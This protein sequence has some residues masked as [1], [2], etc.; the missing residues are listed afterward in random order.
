MTPGSWGLAASVSSSQH[1]GMLSGVGARGPPSLEPGHCT[2]AL[3]WLSTIPLGSAPCK[4]HF[5]ETHPMDRGYTTHVHI[6]RTDVHNN[7]DRT[8]VHPPSGVR[9]RAP[10]AR[11]AP[12]VSLTD[13]KLLLIDKIKSI[14]HF[15]LI[16]PCFSHKISLHT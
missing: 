3:L 11:C 1:N 4:E 13:H 6:L 7:N 8:E 16:I 9:T 15:T 10:P 12:V 5:S 2:H 14:P